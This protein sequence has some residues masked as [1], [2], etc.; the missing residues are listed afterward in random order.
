MDL[1]AELQQHFAKASALEQRVFTAEEE[2]DEWRS[3]AE[4]AEGLLDGVKSLLGWSFTEIARQD[5]A[6]SDSAEPVLCSVR[7]EPHRAFQVFRASPQHITE[8]HSRG[9]MFEQGERHPNDASMGVIYTLLQRAAELKPSSLI[10]DATETALL[11]ALN[12]F[13]DG[14]DNGF[15]KVAELYSKGRDFG[16][17]LAEASVRNRMA[18]LVRG[19]PSIFEVQDRPLAWKLRNTQA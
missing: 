1:L 12:V 9:G 13:N 4:V 8:F 11:R 5:A 7:F 10:F 3:R 2:R 16:F 14:N 18:N 6:E 15:L 17:E 19:F